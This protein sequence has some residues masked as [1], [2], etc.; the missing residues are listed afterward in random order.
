[1]PGPEHAPAEPGNPLT[2]S[3]TPLSWQGAAFLVWLAVVIAMS[4]LLLQ[5]AIF[6]RGLIAQAEEATGLI[7]DMLQDCCE[8]MALRRKVGLKVS[9]NA[10]SPAVC[11]LFRPVILLP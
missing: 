5:R 8:K 11:G 2:V 10:T 3:V 1:M 6:V 7:K 4:L 9:P